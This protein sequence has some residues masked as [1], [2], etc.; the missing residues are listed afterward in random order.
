MPRLNPASALLALVL[1][2]FSNAQAQESSAQAQ[3]PAAASETEEEPSRWAQFKDPEDGM[4][5]MSAYLLEKFA[6]F[7]PVPIIITEP[8]VDDGLGLG[9]IFFHK[10][11][12]DQMQPDEE[13]KVILPNITVAGGAVTGNDSW[14]VGGG[15]FRNWSKDKYRY[16]GMGGYADINLDWYPAEDSPLPDNGIRFNIKGVLVDQSLFMRIGQSEWLVGAGW[17]YAT[18]EVDFDLPLPPELF[19]GDS[20]ISGL[21]AISLYEDVDYQ[22]S[23]RK[24]LTVELK[25]SFNRDAFG[26]DFDYDEI[27]WE[28][29]HYFELGEKW[30]LAW[31]VDG[32]SISGDAPFYAQ[33]FV[34]IQGIPA[35]RYQGPAAATVEVRGGYDLTPRWT[36]NAFVGGGRAADSF[37]DLSSATT[38]S[39]VGG[40]FR[41]LIA[42]KLGM[43]VGIDIATSE[44]GTYAYLVMG[45][46]W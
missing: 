14:F 29:R 20:T 16:R 27:T 26:S 22:L 3:E 21:S 18:S 13:G 35:M 6:G 32:A 8:A 5:D 23:P 2:H 41:Y 4:F 10:P 12:A 19:E 43:R 30:T 40:G 7:M 38:H 11:K 33:P 1:L 17:R 9:G 45:Q 46:A 28:Y 34:K 25:A 24:G 31:R 42:R 15:H 44:E 37:S 39:S 36:L